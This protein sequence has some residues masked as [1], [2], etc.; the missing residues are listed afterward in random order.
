MS[1]HLFSGAI[2]TGYDDEIGASGESFSALLCEKSSLLA[3]ECGRE[4]R[5]GDKER[6]K[7]DADERQR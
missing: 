2:T 6:K 4:G 7:T 5:G 3:C 1:F